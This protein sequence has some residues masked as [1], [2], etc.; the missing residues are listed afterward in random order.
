[1]TMKLHQKK[2]IQLT[3]LVQGLIS[4]G[5]CKKPASRSVSQA[6]AVPKEHAEQFVGLLHCDLIRRF[7]KVQPTMLLLCTSHLLLKPMPN[8]P[9]AKF[10]GRYPV[11]KISILPVSA[12]CYESHLES[13]L[14][15]LD[16]L[17]A[18][19]LVGSSNVGLASAT[20]GNSLARSG[21]AAVEVH[22]VDTNRRIVLDTKIDV[23]AYTEA[24]VASLR[25]VALSELVFLDLQSTL[26]DF[27]SLWS[28]DSDV[29]SDLLVTTDTEG[30]DGVSS[31]ACGS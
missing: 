9:V 13:V 18:L 6:A 21:H 24:E 7:S 2:I 19:D 3:T 31:L 20:L 28:T 11:G 23:F 5:I 30:S 1:M 17:L 25:E 26:Q 8:E 15:P 29:H 10:I 4:N 16:G 14:E 12:A 27:L 22:S